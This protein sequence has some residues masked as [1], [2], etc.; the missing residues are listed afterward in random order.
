MLSLK[1]QAKYWAVALSAAML[2][3]SMN[4]NFDLRPAEREFFNTV[5]CPLVSLL[6]ECES[7]VLLF[8]PKQWRNDLVR[9]DQYDG[10]N[11]QKNKRSLVYYSVLGGICWFM[12]FAA[13]VLAEGS[14]KELLKYQFLMHTLLVYLVVTNAECWRRGVSLTGSP[15]FSWTSC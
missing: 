10:D 7:W 11:E 9:D 1:T 2:F 15:S 13:R 6:Y 12:G 14:D 5:V 3:A 4:Q 8:M